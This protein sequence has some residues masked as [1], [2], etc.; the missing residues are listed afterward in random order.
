VWEIGVKC[1][2]GRQA[3]KGVSVLVGKSWVWK[4]LAGAE[5]EVTDLGECIVYV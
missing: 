4:G 2:G 3:E 5:E 1:S